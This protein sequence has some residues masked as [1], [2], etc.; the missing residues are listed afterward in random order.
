MKNMILV[1][2]LHGNEGFGLE[3]CNSQSLFPFVLANEKVLKEKK[4]FID[5]DLNRVFSG[6]LEGNY[7]ERRAAE[8]SH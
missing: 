8:N 6:K 2:C 4:R 5:A 3:V 7:E 1:C